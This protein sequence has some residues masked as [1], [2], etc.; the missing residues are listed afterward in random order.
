MRI[1]DRFE[2]SAKTLMDLILDSSFDG[3]VMRAIGMRKEVIEDREIEG[4]KVEVVRMIPST[5]LPSF[6]KKVVGGSNEYTE[7]RT[8]TFDKMM[9]TWSE[10]TG[11][12]QDKIDIRGTFVIKPAGDG[13]CT[14]VVEGD[15][16][17]RIPL[18]GKKIEEFIIERT[19]ESFQRSTAFTKKWI[20]DKGLAGK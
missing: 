8:W 3:E 6:M 11:F 20:K 2:C 15:F 17:V 4:G 9:N 10:K 7:T 13:A 18:V 14:R 12:A 19:K 1:E 16:S 5:D